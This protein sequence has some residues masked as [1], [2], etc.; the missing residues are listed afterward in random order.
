MEYIVNGRGITEITNKYNVAPT[1]VRSW[2]KSAI[3]KLRQLGV[4]M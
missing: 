3:K 1:T 4:T 2:R